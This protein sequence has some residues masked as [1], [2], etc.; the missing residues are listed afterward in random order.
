VFLNNGV[1]PSKF[2]VQEKSACRNKLGLPTERKIGVC[3]GSL[4]DVKDQSLLLRSL[5][6]IRKGGHEVPMLVLVG[7][8]PNRLSLIEESISLGLAQDVIF[9]GQKTHQEVAEWMGAAD[10]LLLSSRSE[11]WATVYFEAMAC[12]RPVITSNVS[13]ALDAISKADYGQVVEPRDAANFAMAIRQAMSKS[14]DSN[15]IRN[16]AE[17]HTWKKWA[18]RFG[19]T[20]KSIN[21][22]AT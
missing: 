10:W 12:G 4:I 7:D 1:D 14:Y 16:Y 5:A 13:S 22:Q 17:S 19:E 9:A 6:E 8:G 11:G 21:G 2:T 20:L 3:V 15:V 18:Q